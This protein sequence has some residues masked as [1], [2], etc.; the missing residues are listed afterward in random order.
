M[1]DTNERVAQVKERAARIQKKKEKRMIRGLSTLCLVLCCC[2]V[3]ILGEVSGGFGSAVAVQGLNGAT[4]LSER[5]GGY[6]L[7]AVVS[8]VTAVVFTLLCVKLRER[9]QKSDSD[10]SAAEG[11]ARTQ[12]SENEN[13]RCG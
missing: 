13:E 1:Y 5:T 7:V 8:F 2:L 10:C 6:V 11:I 9:K 3:G 4:L 12:K